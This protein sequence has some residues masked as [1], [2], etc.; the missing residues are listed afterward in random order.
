VALG[1]S[2]CAL[3]VLLAVL[4]DPIVRVAHARGEQRI[5]AR[6]AAPAERRAEDKDGDKALPQESGPRYR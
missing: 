3:A 1:A 5:L 2:C 4:G 6:L